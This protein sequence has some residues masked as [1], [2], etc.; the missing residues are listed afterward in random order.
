MKILLADQH[1]HSERSM[2]S[3][4]PMEEM[5][6]AALTHGVGRLCFT[7]HIDIDDALTGLPDDSCLERWPDTER[8]FRHAREAVP[9]SALFVG[10]ELGEPHHRPDWAETITSAADCDLVLG[11]LHNLRGMKDFYFLEYESEED[12]RRL[13]RL[14]MAE[15]LELAELDCFDV[16]A[17]IGYTKRYMRRAGFGASVDLNSFGDEIRT[18]LCRLIERGKGIELNCSGLRDGGGAF[19]PPEVLRL[20]RELGGEIITVGSDAHSADTAGIGIA[21]GYALLR[22]AGFRYVSL[23]HRRRPE[24]EKL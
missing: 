7:D 18:L 11:S 21:E 2:D 15:L 6:R 23:F 1:I 10:M 13:N 16:M 20:Y 5:A 14:Y 19:P 24:F 3:E 17:H 12:C 22:E 8:A 9:E 4:T